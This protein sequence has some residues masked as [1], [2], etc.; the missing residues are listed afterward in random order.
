M[1]VAYHMQQFL[2]V[3]VYRSIVT[4]SLYIQEVKTGIHELLL[5]IQQ[6][7]TRDLL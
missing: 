5:F 3:P 6:L 2:Y 1:T 4:P 7:H